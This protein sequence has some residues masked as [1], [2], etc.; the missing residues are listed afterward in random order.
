MEWKLTEERHGQYSQALESAKEVE[1]NLGSL[2]YKMF[3]MNRMRADI[4]KALKDWWEEVLVEM[5]LDKNKNYMITRD[6]LIQ[7]V[8][9]KKEMEPAAPVT[10]QGSTVA[11]L[12]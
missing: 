4:D 11:D 3:Q 12:V 10:G 2:T 5:N 1:A 7:D 9:P 6:G 8:T